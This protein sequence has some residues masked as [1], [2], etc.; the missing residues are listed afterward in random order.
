MAFVYTLSD[1]KSRMNSGIQGKK[2]ILLSQDDLAN[3]AVREVGSEVRL[4]SKRRRQTL[5]PN[6]FSGIF[7]YACPSDL[8]S[9][10]IIDI[11][12]QAKREDGEFEFVPSEQFRRNP[13]KGDIS[14]DDFN[15]VRILLINSE[16]DDNEQTIDPVT[17]ISSN[18]LVWEA[19]GDAEN[20]A[21]DS[22]RYVKGSGS[23]EFGI[24]SAGGTTAG[25]FTND[26]DAIDLS[27]YILSAASIFTYARITDP[28]NITNYKILIGTDASNNYEYTVTTRNDGTAFAAGQNL[29]RFDLATPT[30][31]NGSPDANNI[32]YAAM[33]MTKTAGKISESDYAFNWLTAKKGKYHDV[34]YYSKYGWKTSTGTYIE[35]ATD[36]SDF[37]VAD[38]DEYDLIVKKARSLAAAEVDLPQSKI[39]ELVDKY[40]SARM[41]YQNE[42]PSEEKT[43]ISSYYGY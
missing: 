3:E 8:H 1:L 38:T 9:F 28:T 42:N 7:E 15:G 39:K 34:T 5:S 24:S 30:A 13:R 22:D 41:N 27:D 32:V 29:L 36:E 31:T 23:V 25:I 33:Y 10:D 19:F 37:L 40:E 6:L 20:V 12:A 11:P 18:G 21:T 2:G 14:I 16:V 4:R 35:N 26:L 17:S 43:I